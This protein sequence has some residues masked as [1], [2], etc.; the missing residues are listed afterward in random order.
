MRCVPR[1]RRNEVCL[2]GKL[3]RA[4]LPASEVENEEE[5]EGYHEHER[6]VPNILRGLQ[7]ALAWGLGSVF[8]NTPQSRSDSESASKPES[9]SDIA[10][11]CPARA[12]A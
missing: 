9:D 4:C 5:E 8:L 1:R 3:R 2:D 7:T 10:P 12:R 11:R 6:P